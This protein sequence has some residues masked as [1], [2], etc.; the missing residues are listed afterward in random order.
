MVRFGEAFLEELKSRVRPSDVVGRH[1]K[2]R[3]Q[4]RE[5]A[6]L[7]PFT[8]E[9]T[10]SFFV[11]DQKGFYHCFSSGKHGDAISFLMEIEGLSFPEAV[12]RLADMAGMEMPKA[13]PVSAARAAARAEA[14]R[15]TVSWLERAQSH[16][17][18]NLLGER[19][20]QAR[21]YL[22]GRT[23]DRDTVMEFGL[24]FATDGYTDLK[25]ELTR[26][27]AE[28]GDLVAAG[29]LV[30]PEDRG[31]DPWDRF[32]D[33]IMFPIHDARGRLVAFGGRAMSKEARAKYLNSPETDVFHKGRLLYNYH[34]ARAVVADPKR[35]SAGLIVAEGYMDVSAL[36]RAGFGEAVAPLGTALTED[37]IGLLW[38]AAP[39]AT[40]CFDGDAAG[41]RAAFRSVE[42]VLPLLRPGHTL[43]FALLPEGQDPDDLIRERGREAI[44]EVLDRAVSLVDMLWEREVREADTDSPEGRAALKSRLFAA[45]SEI[46]D[47]EVRAQY[48][49]EL[50]GRF[51]RLYGRARGRDGGSWNRTAAPRRPNA[52][53]KASMAPSRMSDVAERRLIAGVLEFPEILEV[54]DEDVFGLDFRS[55]LARD[56]QGALLDFWRQNTAVDKSRVRAHM[57]AEGL[58]HH[59]DSLAPKR[60]DTVASLGGEDADIQTRTA[61]WKALLESFT[62]TQAHASS[63]E[64]RSRMAET[65]RD[66]NT[67]GLHRLMR[68]RRISPDEG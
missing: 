67:D 68:A 2:L 48:R 40:L 28:V 6:G 12:E 5:Y 44:R 60:R 30:E 16:Y 43:R 18:R 26:E 4:G 33:R 19:G 52:A 1:V 63:A 23:L 54:V 9:K 32:R 22:K 20:A 24:G 35:E 37:Q 13:D 53:L 14:A 55:P 29:L 58:G 49:T 59:M 3:R 17:M 11:N 47:E 66:E 27:G 25:S 31:R 65:I 21:A 56:L 8:N 36:H 61:L 10:P 34:R 7:S 57:A 64:T 46:G 41:L 42:R 50:L 39:S 15:T 62:G 51:D 45:F 38:R